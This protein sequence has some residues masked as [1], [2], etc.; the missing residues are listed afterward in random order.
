VDNP[1]RTAAYQAEMIRRRADLA[2]TLERILPDSTPFVWELGC[3]HGHMLTAY[4]QAH[5]DRV[6][7]GVDIASDRIVRAMR[8]RERA[9]LPN[10]FFLHAEARLFL[11]VMPRHAQLGAI[12]ILFPDPWPKSRHHKHRILQPTFLDAA[13]E[14]SA[15]DCRLYFRTDYQPYFH[16][17]EAAVLG[18]PAWQITDEAWPFE[19]ETVFQSR[20]PNFH[21]LIARRPT[22]TTQRTVTVIS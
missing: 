19:F 1:A 15:P 18:H 11:D 20:A 14:R 9:Q 12:F 16:D 10:L 8:K 5:P 22:A 13:A 3:G 6:C 7:I 17:A 21:S 4:A 2:T